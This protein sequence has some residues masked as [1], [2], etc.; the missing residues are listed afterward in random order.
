MLKKGA[1]MAVS[2]RRTHM[3]TW[4]TPAVTEQSVGLEVTSYASAEVDPV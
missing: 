4:E 2:F 1:A 3:K